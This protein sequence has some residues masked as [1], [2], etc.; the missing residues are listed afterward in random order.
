MKNLGADILSLSEERHCKNTNQLCSRTEKKIVSG[1]LNVQCVIRCF[2]T[3]FILWVKR[4]LKSIG[5]N[6]GLKKRVYCLG[7]FVQ[8]G[9]SKKKLWTVFKH[10]MITFS[11]I[12]VNI[13]VYITGIQLRKLRLEEIRWFTGDVTSVR[14]IK[15]SFIWIWI[16]C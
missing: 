2:D 5:F 16:L 7:S 11:V 15:L 6:L 3:E 4:D 9:L 12:L 1:L 8:G 13:R 14:K 10:K